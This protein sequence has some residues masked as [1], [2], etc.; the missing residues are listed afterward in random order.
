LQTKIKLFEVY[1]T[2]KLSVFQ[3]QYFLVLELKKELKTWWLVNVIMR[4]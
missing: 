4:N 2:V 3:R 1:I